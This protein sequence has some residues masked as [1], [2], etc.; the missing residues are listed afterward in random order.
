[1][2]ATVAEPPN[3]R[4]KVDGDDADDDERRGERDRA[5]HGDHDKEDDDD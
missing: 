3:L 5:R 4:A 2:A 1:M